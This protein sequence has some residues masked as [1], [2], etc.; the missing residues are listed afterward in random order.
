MYNQSIIKL[1]VWSSLLKILICPHL[2]ND[3][4]EKKKLDHISIMC[5]F[6]HQSVTTTLNDSLLIIQ[7]DIEEVVV[8]WCT[9]N[10]IMLI[11]E[12]LL[13]KQDCI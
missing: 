9:V 11:L 12:M 6:F 1:L 8:F 10:V 3:Y 2:Q 13:S 5:A 4:N 7:V